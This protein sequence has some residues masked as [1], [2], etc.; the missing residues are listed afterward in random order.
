MAD[1]AQ[2][3]TGVHTPR[4]RGRTFSA[5]LRAIADGTSS[6]RVSVENLWRQWVIGDLVR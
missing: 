1:D 6:D 3:A 2:F 5:I 4:K